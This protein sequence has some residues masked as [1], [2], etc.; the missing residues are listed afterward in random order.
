LKKCKNKLKEKRIK[1]ITKIKTACDIIVK[2]IERVSSN[3]PD[4]RELND[5]RREMVLIF[6]N[7]KELIGQSKKI[8]ASI[9]VIKELEL[10]AIKSIGRETSEKKIID[11]RKHFL[12]RIASVVKRLD[13]NFARIRV[14]GKKLSTIP[15]LKDDYP[16][17]LLAGLPNTGKTTLL[18]KLTGSKAK[19][20]GYAFTT[21]K[22][23]IGYYNK[24]YLDYQVIDLPGLLDREEKLNVIEKQV[25]AALRFLPGIIVFVLDPSIK[26]EIGRQKK[27][28]EKLKKEIEK[29]LI[30]YVSKTDIVEKTA[31]EKALKEFGEEKY[32]FNASE[33]K[34]SFK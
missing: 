33:I 25:L 17:L 34:E 20:A 28:K 29:K 16:T 5:F 23:Q 22:I 15:K 24:K 21:T 26:E 14:L 31:V 6:V 19:I 12:G 2:E 9:K 32:C 3:L 13:K 30:V 8:T 7:R 1:E 11:N 10:K 18:E 4:V 27:L